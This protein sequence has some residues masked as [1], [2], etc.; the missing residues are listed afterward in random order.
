[1][2]QIDYFKQRF[3]QRKEERDYYIKKANEETFLSQKIEYLR[4]A[5]VMEYMM[6][7]TQNI[8]RDIKT[9]ETY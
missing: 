7:E 1:M 9:Y 4:Q 6:A 3:E 5:K 8:G 2:G